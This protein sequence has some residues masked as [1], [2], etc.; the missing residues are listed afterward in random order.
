M[1]T[2]PLRRPRLDRKPVTPNVGIQPRPWGCRLEQRV[3]PESARLPCF[4][5]TWFQTQATTY[6]AGLHTTL[7]PTSRQ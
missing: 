5:A 4:S 2:E 7:P 3:R 1:E 6:L